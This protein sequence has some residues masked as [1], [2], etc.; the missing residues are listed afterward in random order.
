[1]IVINILK[2]ISLQVEHSDLDKRILLLYYIQYNTGMIVDQ[3]M[4]AIVNDKDQ[5]NKNVEI[6]KNYFKSFIIDEHKSETNK[7]ASS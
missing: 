7:G 1:M 4:T 2:E 3:V 5:Y 6:A